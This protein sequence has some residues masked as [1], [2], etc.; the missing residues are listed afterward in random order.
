MALKAAELGSAVAV[1]LLGTTLVG[2]G[3]NTGTIQHST[4][5]TQGAGTESAETTIDG[6]VTVDVKKTLGP[7][8]SQIYGI[9][10]PAWDETLFQNGVLNPQF[11]SEA[12]QAGFG[13]L[14][15]PGGNYGYHFVWNKMNLPT[16][17][18]TDQ[19]LSV[20]KKLHATPKISVNPTESP[21]L[22]AD[23]VRYVNKTKKAYVTYW[24]IAD[25]PYLTMS[26]DQF[27]QKMKEF[28]PKMKKVDPSIKIIANVSIYNPS[29]TKKVIQEIGNLI[30][31]Y[32]IHIFPL[33]PSN[34]FSASS[35]YSADDKQKFFND[36]L[37]SPS[38]LPE[39]LD[40][41][42]SW[43]K[44]DYPHKRVEYQIGSYNTVWAYPEDWTTDSLPAALWTADMLGEFA[45]VGVDAA[46]Y[47]AAMNPYPPGQGDY[48]MFNPAMKPNVDYYPFVLYH[49]HFGTTLVSSSTS[50]DNLSVYASKD[51]KNNLYLMVINKNSDKNIDMKVRL[52][53]FKARGDAAAWILDG[54]TVA[55]NPSDYGLRKQS[56]SKVGHT[57][58]WTVPSYSVAA[59]EIPAARSKASLAET[60]NLAQYKPTTASSVALNTDTN[61]YKTYDFTADKATDGD[62]TTRWASKIFQNDNEWLKVDLGQVQPINDFRMSWE[63]PATQYEIEVSS[64]D[65]HWQKV[66]DQSLVN[67]VKPGPQPVQEITLDKAVDAR[68][69]RIVMTGRPAQSGAAAGSSQ[70]TPQAYSLWEF[71]IYLK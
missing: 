53:D 36:L 68:Y 21:Q 27:I 1:A 33:P 55:D 12:K 31:V 37:Q 69:V 59:I 23:W 26:A 66:A 40:T 11:L 38:Q 10:L 2:C 54:P 24:E 7:I 60:P 4:K 56:I 22:A 30:D 70:W 43:V 47:W 65:N 14:V 67:T 42:K 17:M 34:K 44:A 51:K 58:Q 18:N 45:K 35:P 63:Y 28:V 64:D 13:F 3:V 32:S 20:C 71:G 39:Q 61:Y 41:L 52:N 46:A 6:Q 62:A 15:Y 48:G 16:E 25:E 29:F 50:T 9:H 49:E 5:N 57:L 19:F 8:N